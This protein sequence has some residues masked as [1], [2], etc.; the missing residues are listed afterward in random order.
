MN[1]RQKLALL[2]AI[3]LGGVGAVAAIAMSMSDDGESTLSLDAG[4]DVDSDQPNTAAVPTSTT[5]SS[6]SSSTTTMATPTTATTATTAPPVVTTRAAAVT[7]S[8]APARKEP[9]FDMSPTSGP[10]NTRVTLSGSGCQGADYGIAVYVYD[11]N[12]Q[13]FNGDGGAAQPDGTWRL[14][15][16]IGAG[17]SGP[18]DYTVRANCQGPGGPVFSY[19]P[20]TF[21]QTG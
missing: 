8:T 13:G 2:A 3:T 20:R 4:G 1:P 7:S 11:A 6:T 5:S 14:D 16:S 15:I 12:G 17:P 21:T 9:T 19:A 10:P 18:G